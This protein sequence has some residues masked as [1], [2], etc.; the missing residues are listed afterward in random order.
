GDC[1]HRLAET[2]RKRKYRAA[3]RYE[4]TKLEAQVRQLT[5]YIAHL[6]AKLRVQGLNR[7]VAENS[8]LRAKVDHF[9]YLLVVLSH[10]AFINE[11]PQ[12]AL[13]H[14]PA[15][16]E[17]TLLA[18]PISRRQ[19]IQWLSERVYNEARTLLPL[20]H[21]C[22]GQI[23]DAFT[24]DVHLSDD[25]DEEG[26]TIAALETHYQHTTCTNYRSAASV[27]WNTL[28]GAVEGISRALIDLDTPPV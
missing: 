27:H 18:H 9:Q 23:D 2:I 3:K 20:N 21:P 10:W 14:R 15:C 4:L 17:S 24:L 22:L 12:Q 6:K 1:E 13:S 28:I 26:T 8:S 19:G 7:C 25:L 11:A 16:I 5:G